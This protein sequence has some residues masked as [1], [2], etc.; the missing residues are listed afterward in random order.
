M[1][2]Q[3][4]PCTC[5]LGGNTKNI[6]NGE[7]RKMDKL[8][9]ECGIVGIYNK[10]KLKTSEIIYTG[11]YMLQHRGQE[12]AGIAIA[13]K[14]DK[15]I[16]HKGM[17]LVSEVFDSFVLNTL[18]GDIGIGHV[19]YSTAGGSGVENAQP[20]VLKYMKGNLA[21]AHNGNL[22]NTNDLREELQK[23]GFVFQ[24]TTDTEVM[25]ALLA[26]EH[27]KN[28]SLEESLLEVLKLISGAYSIVIMAENK[29]I[30]V[31]D[32]NGIRPLCLGKIGDS[33]VVVSESVALNPIGAEFIRD[34]EPGEIV[35]I[36]ESG[37][38]SINFKEDKK[39]ALCVFEHVYF[40]RPDSKIDG[41]SVYSA[42]LEAGRQLAIENKI[43]A[44]I[45]IGVPDSGIPS[46][47][48]YSRESGIPY[49]EGF[50]KNRYIGRTFIQ[51]SQFLREK[52][53][54][55]KLS[56][57]EEQVSGKRVIMIDDSIVRGTTS[58][59][60]VN[61]LKEAGATEVHVLISSP[62]VKYSCYLGVDT[63]ERENLIANTHS[64]EE[65]RKEIEADSLAFLS[66]DGLR[67]APCK[68]KLGFCMACFDG[69][70]PVEIKDKN[71]KKC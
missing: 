7:G 70:Y 20:V 69:N 17:G 1:G 40:A 12:S 51:P 14:Q 36:D 28:E 19:R 68:S 61:L 15:I 32:P 21:V 53:V 62:P 29:L 59:K 50:I 65:I 58:K 46:A 26:R 60:I 48:G 2:D 30:A 52:S 54:K 39:T 41:Q 9:E 23:M 31:R 63:P 27:I 3:R 57:L 33:Y 25:A 8:K 34:I 56:A 43:N 64:I 55:L 13:G 10:D 47:I 71:T 6:K 16:V 22:V 11:L 4:E 49:S 35:V 38:K 66:I 18:E 24:S 37:L 45:V 5:P 67:N 42:R 44:D